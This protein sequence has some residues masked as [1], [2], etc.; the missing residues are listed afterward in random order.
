MA[1]EPCTLYVHTLP[2]PPCPP[3]PPPPLGSSRLYKSFRGRAW[4]RTTILTA[5]VFPGS[6]FLLFLVINTFLSLYHSSGAVPFLQILAVFSLWLCVSV[7]LVFFGAFFGYKRETWEYPTVTSTIPREV[8][9]LPWY[10]Q[11]VTVVGLGGVLP[12]GAAY[13]ELFYILSSIWMDQY[14][15]VFGFTFMVCFILVVTCGE[16]AILFCYFQLCAEDYRWWWRS[17]LSAGSTAFY[18][19][20]YSCVWFQLLDPSKLFITYLLYFGYMGLISFAIF[21]VCGTIGFLSCFWFTT[22]IFASIKVD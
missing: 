15:Y 6:A 3:H 8:P 14:Y 9:E 11:S 10:L 17:F 16:L 13:V 5:S 20:A 1:C 21:C 12:F 2:H 7:P 4:Q 18:V 19:F 22:K